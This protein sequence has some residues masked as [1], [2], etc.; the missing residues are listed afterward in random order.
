[1]GVATF[2]AEAGRFRREGWVRFPGFL[3]SA[4]RAALAPLCERILDQ[5]LARRAARSD[6]TRQTNLAYLTDPRYFAGRPDDLVRLLEF[7]ADPRI[8]AILGAVGGAVPVFHNTQL[9][10][11][12]PEP[13]WA[14]P[15]HRDTQF[16]A[17]DPALERERMARFTSVHFRVAFEDDARLQFVPGSER[18][19]DTAEEESIR[20]GGNPEAAASDDMP[21][22]ATLA[23]KAGDA[24]LFHAW[25]I[26]RGRRYGAAPRRRTLDIIYMWGAENDWAPAHATCFADEAART[27]ILARLSPH[28]RAFF[29]RFVAVYRPYWKRSRAP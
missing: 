6:S 1:M 14:G 16:L 18:R 2:E 15:W 9:F 19:W 4:E 11:N 29:E 22:A 5:W 12:P 20:R 27:A 26:H 21:K 24:L 3:A 28:A 10:H 25:G 13:D 23:M 7:V 17:R 8:L